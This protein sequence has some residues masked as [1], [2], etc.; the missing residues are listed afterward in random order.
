MSTT[1]IDIILTVMILIVAALYAAVGQAG[2]T[3]YLAVMALVGVAPDMMKPSALTLNVLVAAIGSV[4][5]AHAGLLH[6]RS[7]Y[8]FAVLGAPF[9][10]IGG[11]I[12]M[13]ASYYNPVVGVILLL[14]AMQLIRSARGT[15]R[16]DLDA[17]STPPFLSALIAGAIIGFISGMTGTGGGIFLA[18]LILLFGWVDTR[19][20]V[21]VSAAYNL[22]NSAAALLGAMAS[23]T[24]LP[25]G[26][27]WWLVAAGVGGLLGSWLG[28]RHL[29]ATT[30]RYVLAALLLVSGFKMILV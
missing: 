13:P 22:L 7:F 25:A 3:G 5:F 28:A 8:P 23:I 18:P 12:N 9:S 21:A 17:P 20:T 24:H 30:L 1:I 29:S 16:H 4:R 26:L 6:W 10:L 2:A 27:P 15:A 11:T 14:A 19:R